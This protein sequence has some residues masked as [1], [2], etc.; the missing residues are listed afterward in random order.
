M[1]EQ[2]LFLDQIKDEFDKIDI[3]EDCSSVLVKKFLQPRAQT[4]FENE[5]SDL[6]LDWKEIYSLAFSVTLDTSLRAFQYKLLN[7]IV[8]AK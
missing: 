3:D 4:K 6:S 1:S 5:Y 2:K 8:Y 7:R